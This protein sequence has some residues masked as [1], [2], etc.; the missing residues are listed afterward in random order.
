MG[1]KR[2]SIEERVECIHAN[3][4][5]ALSMMA[6]RAEFCKFYTFCLI[7][8][9]STVTDDSYSLSLLL[10]AEGHK[11]M[12]TEDPEDDEFISLHGVSSC[13]EFDAADFKR[14]IM[15]LIDMYGEKHVHPVI[16]DEYLMFYSI[17][18]NYTME[19]LLNLLDTVINSDDWSLGAG[20]GIVII[21]YID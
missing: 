21:E 5:H 7:N 16:P 4:S 3:A 15:A 10:G 17:P 1:N 6:D 19:D 2:K 14:A 18:T 12:G 8:A 9:E 13:T 20:F 11:D